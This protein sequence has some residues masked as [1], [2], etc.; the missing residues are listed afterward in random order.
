MAGSNY[1]M[2]K[3]DIMHLDPKKREEYT[4]ISIIIK[5]N[6]ITIFFNTKKTH[7]YLSKANTKVNWNT[8]VKFNK[9]T[10]VK[11][12]RSEWIKKLKNYLPANVEAPVL[13]RYDGGGDNVLWL[14]PPEKL[15]L[16]K[17]PKPLNR[18]ENVFV[19]VVVDVWTWLVLLVELVLFVVLLLLIELFAVATGVFRFELMSRLL[20]LFRPLALS[21]NSIRN[22][23]SCIDAV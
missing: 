2:P 9:S 18:P 17:L 20:L 12:L 3:N 23:Y 13:G 5:A 7:I 11:H 22:L 21:Y 6:W 15:L 10:A 14:L 1:R 16:T 8:I 4:I 19:V